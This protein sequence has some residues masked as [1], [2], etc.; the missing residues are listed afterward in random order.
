MEVEFDRERQRQRAMQEDQRRREE[1]E[2][3]RRL[4]IWERH[5]RLVEVVPVQYNAC[6]ASPVPYVFLGGGRRHHDTCAV[7]SLHM[8]M[9]VRQREGFG[10]GLRSRVHRP[11]VTSVGFS[12]WAMLVFV[13][14]YQCIIV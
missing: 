6:A 3:Q 1:R 4:D 12:V 7:C 13:S 8:C 11:C 5:E 10:K 2:F 14:L 9:A